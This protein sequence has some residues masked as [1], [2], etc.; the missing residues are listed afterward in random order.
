MTEKLNPSDP[1]ERD[2]ALFEAGIK[3]GSL[4]HQFVGSPLSLSSIASLEVA[5]R[6]SISVQPYAESV[7]VRIDKK[8]VKEELNKTFGYTELKGDML[9]VQAVIRYYSVRVF[10]SLEYDKQACY[11][12]MK[13]D[14][15]EEG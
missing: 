5:I 3:L 2:C 9:T 8:R 1:S 6:D 11:P 13:I 10:V 12:L 4:Y 14:K 15:I 7:S